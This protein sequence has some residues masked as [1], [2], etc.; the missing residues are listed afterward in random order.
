MYFTQT[1]IR[2]NQVVTMSEYIST[3]LVRKGEITSYYVAK[4][5]TNVYEPTV[6]NTICFIKQTIGKD[7]YDNQSNIHKYRRIVCDLL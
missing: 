5:L 3:R 2:D 7:S 4:C 1:A 6:V